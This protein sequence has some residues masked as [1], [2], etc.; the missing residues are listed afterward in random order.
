[1]KVPYFIWFGKNHCS[2]E[3]WERAKDPGWNMNAA[4]A[5]T[6]VLCVFI[7]CYTPYLYALLPFQPIDYHPY[8]SYHVSETMQVL[9]FTALGFFLFV[10]QLAP[11]PTI[12][13]DLDWFY[14]MGGRA[15]L[16]VA[17]R[18][19]QFIDTV[20]GEIYRLGGLLPLKLTAWVVNLFD[21]HVIDGLV[22]GFAASVRSVGNR[23]RV[24]QR[25][26]VQENLTLVFAVAVVLVLAF[27]FF[28]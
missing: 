13:L 17:K 20:V 26:S 14:R 3:V 21:Q 18:P 10:K 19:L 12:S 7:G 9:L 4:M 2:K 28:F 5:I 25:G 27:L 24:A 1:L 22:D 15:F 11:E 6:A 23:L 16:W 8:T